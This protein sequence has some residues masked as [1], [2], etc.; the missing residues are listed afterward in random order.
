MDDC[1]LLE[2]FI[3]HLVEWVMGL[4]YFGCLV[5]RMFRRLLSVVEWFIHDIV[6]MNCFSQLVAGVAV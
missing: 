3:I 4:G 5:D 6:W 2:G 1:S